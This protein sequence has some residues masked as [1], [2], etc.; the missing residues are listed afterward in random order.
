[1]REYVPFTLLLRRVHG[2]NNSQGDANSVVNQVQSNSLSASNVAIIVT[3][4]II[5]TAILST[6]SSCF[7]LRYRRKR[8]SARGEEAPV[9]NKKTYEKPVAVRGSPSPR[10]PRFGRD[11]GSS[12]ESFKLPRLSPLVQ[13]KKAQREEQKNIGYATSNYSD[14][15]EKGSRVMSDANE[16]LS[17][18]EDMQPSAFRLQ[19]KNG[20]SSATTVR[21]IRV[22]SEKGKAN[23]STDAQQSETRPP[24]LPLPVTVAPDKSSEHAPTSV[25]SQPTMQSTSTAPNIITQP[26]KAKE[27]PPE[28]QRMSTRSTRDLEAEM[29]GW[30]PPIRST[31]T[32]SQ[33]RFRFRDSSDLESG[34]PTPTDMSGSLRRP[35]NAG[36]SFATFP[37]IRNEPPPRR[38]SMMNRG[39]PSLNSTA[40]RLRG[41]DR[42]LGN[43][44]I[45]RSSRNIFDDR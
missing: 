40:A 22:G 30:R 43:R 5:G 6:L 27:P 38:E 23:S 15:A 12:T 18:S 4:S 20:V 36:A 17:D 9:G 24:P 26:L 41:D 44:T 13:P 45:V 8:R 33:N 3:V 31:M 39:R 34:E 2:S 37:R 42:G 32:S 21:L 1:V 14:K 35:K 16:K 28:Q 10:F 25:S 11:S 7:I 19:K 29:P